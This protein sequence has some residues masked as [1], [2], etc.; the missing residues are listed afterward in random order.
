[1][2]K[3]RSKTSTTKSQIEDTFQDLDVTLN[4]GLEVVEEIEEIVEEVIIEAKPA[5]A[6]KKVIKEEPKAPGVYYNGELITKIPS[7]LGSKWTIVY[8]GKRHKVLKQ[9][10]EF[11]K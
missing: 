11:I 4:D 1:M 8:Q 7:R 6:P 2:A 9:D 5:P 10:L 3:R